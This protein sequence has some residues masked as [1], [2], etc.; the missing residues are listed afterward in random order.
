ML[1]HSQARDAWC[2][3]L[4]QL[5]YHVKEVFHLPLHD[6][7]AWTDST[8]LLSWLV[9]NPKRF[10]TYIGKRISCI[11]DK[12]A[13]DRRNHVTGAENPADCASRGL[14]P[15]ELLE[16]KLWWSGP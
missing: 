6:V 10:K 3:S 4:V 2:L 12:I 7:Y 16:H 14:F 1:V 8:I 13:S 5:L 15:S 9:G 11:V